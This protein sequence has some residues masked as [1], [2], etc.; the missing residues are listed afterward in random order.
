MLKPGGEPDLALKAFRPQ[1]GG[2]LRVEDLQRDRAVV[3]EVIG[4]IDRRH[5][6]PAEL[7]LDPVTVAEGLGEGRIDWGHDGLPG[8]E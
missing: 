5:A 1:I 6:A 2:E 3:P 4:Q 8:R 7:A